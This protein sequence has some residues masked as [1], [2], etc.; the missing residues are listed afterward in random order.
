M[1]LPPSTPPPSPRIR[2]RLVWAS[3]WIVVTALLVVFLR[4]VDWDAVAQR[5]TAAHWGWVAV[6]V[7]ANYLILVTLTA[8]WRSLAPPD[9]H[10]AHQRMPEVVALSV[11]GMSTLP[12]GGGHALAVGLLIKRAKL[13]VDSTAALMGMDQFF[14]GVAKVT[15]L[16]LAMLVAPLPGWMEKVVTAMGV[17]LL[18]VLPMLAWLVY[19]NPAHISWLKPWSASVQFLRRPR[20]WLN[21]IGWSLGSKVAEALGILAVQYACGVELPWTSVVVVV[22]AVNIATMISLAPGDL[23][24][25]EA[26]AFAAY[27]LLGVPPETAIT[28]S[29]LQHFACLVALVIP[30]YGYMIARALRSRSSTPL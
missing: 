6:A 8:L 3:V 10:V 7:G 25:Y 17:S 13:R 24:I 9:A 23:G 19:R 26:A 27:T 20:V 15:L 29:I 1:E 30:G 5:L 21:G 28:L 11:A 22:A 4:P 2:P 16:E 14:E 12:F 18:I